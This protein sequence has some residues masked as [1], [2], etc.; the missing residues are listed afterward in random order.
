MTNLNSA[1][2]NNL[3][4]ELSPVCG[5]EIENMRNSESMESDSHGTGHHGTDHHGTHGILFL[6]QIEKLDGQEKRQVL[7]LLD[8][9][10]ERGQL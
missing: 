8:A 2:K 4:D 7:Q 6:Q 10:I 1:Y 9:F 5:V 3:R